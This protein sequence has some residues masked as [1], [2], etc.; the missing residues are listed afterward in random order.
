MERVLHHKIPAR[1]RDIRR[2]RRCTR[3]RVVRTKIPLPGPLRPLP[4]YHYSVQAQDSWTGATVLLE[5]CPKWWA[6]TKT[7]SDMSDIRALKTSPSADSLLVEPL[8]PSSVRLDDLVA[9]DDRL[10][11]D[12]PYVLGLNDCRHH[13]HALL[14]F[15]YCEKKQT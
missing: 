11:R 4:I 10:K 1:I 9:L 14:D 7:A 8:P 3:I 2:A 12:A 13:V 5:K 6:D 15:C